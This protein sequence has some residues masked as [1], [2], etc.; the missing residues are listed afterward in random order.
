MA[1]TKSFAL[2][3]AAIVSQF[4]AAS[5]QCNPL[6]G[7]CP[8]IPGFVDEYSVDF[9]KINSLP[10]E[11][12]LAN[13]ENV[14][15][16]SNGIEF[17][18]VKQG[19]SPYIWTNQYLQYGYVEVV[20]E[21]APGIGVISS[22][23][24]L[25]DDLDEIDWEF[26]GNDFGNTVPTLQTNY[27]GKGITGDYDRGT[28]PHISGN[29]TTQFHTYVLNWTPESLSWY[30][31][32]QNIRTLYAKDCDNSTH[33]YPQTPARFHLGVWDAG[34]PSVAAGTVEW[35]GGYTNMNGFPYSMTVQ[36]VSI[37]PQN[38]CLW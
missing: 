38:Q 12:I 29:M 2:L 33:Q 1:S 13:Y 5:A 14:S 3:L 30:V 24:L 32:G 35:A 17:T 18:L 4:I 11:W 21:T 27:Y 8:P 16:S 36:S 10:S 19:D 26:S 9:T 31:N 7:S 23:V 6:K 20:L 22:A 28:Q 34:D 37:V 25:S 15:F